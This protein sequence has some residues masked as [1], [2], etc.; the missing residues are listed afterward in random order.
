MS[1][2]KAYD[3]RGIYGKDLQ[4]KDA[5]LIGYNFILFTK[6]KSLKIARDYR[7]SSESLTKFFI[8]GAISAGCKIEYQGEI[9][10]ANFY[11]TLFNGINS[12][13]IITASHNPAKYNGFKFMVNLESFDLRNGLG[14]IEKLIYEETQKDHE[15]S[16]ILK[17]FEKTF[18]EINTLSFND[19]L[20]L[21]EII[22]N[23]KSLENYINFLSQFF[24]NQINK[25]DLDILKKI[26]FSIDYSSG[27]SGL[28]LVSLFNKFSLHNITH[29]NFH[30]N[31]NFPNHPP[32]PL[33]AGDY[34]S[35]QNNKG[36]FTAVFDGDGDRV[37][38]YNKNSK[39]IS[40]DKIIEKYIQEF[41]SI[42]D[43][44][45]VDLRVTRN[46]FDLAKQ[47]NFHVEKL[48]VGRAFYQKYMQENDCFFGAELSGH[49][50]FKDFKYLD[51]P[52]IALIYMLKF[53]INK[54]KETQFD[55][56]N[57]ET[58]FN[59]NNNYYKLPEINLEVENADNAINILRE[60][61]SK[62]LVLELDGLSFDLG[63]LWFNIRKSNTEP[64]LRINLE[65]KTESEVI[66]FQEDLKK[67]LK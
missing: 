58:M 45:V 42:Y 28:A 66:S 54:I 10:T 48:R 65:G 19:F 31:G 22:I 15:N 11:H 17:D 43:K 2:F 51:N 35:K 52:D 55:N 12:G 67:L 26:S 41:S 1:I 7:L 30:P 63:N 39:N 33:L 60:K 6:L 62:H 38:F 61:Y 8:Q 21:K 47:N 34:L 14:E 49:F 40:Q 20:K 16:D 29:F 25:K 24:V 37:A 18:D 59:L 56:F 9:S 13:V 64:I 27:M 3:V 23:P 5:Y 57:F 4:E 50:F 44:F 36:L 32:D 53:L 46:I